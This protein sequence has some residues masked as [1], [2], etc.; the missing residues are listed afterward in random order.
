MGSIVRPKVALVVHGADGRHP[1]SAFV[2]VVLRARWAGRLGLADFTFVSPE[3]LAAG[4][5]LD[6]VDAVIVQRDA[7]LD[8]VLATA[9]AG[10]ISRR[11]IRLVHDVDDDFWSEES[12]AR[13]LGQDYSPARLAAFDVASTAADITLVSTAVLATR[14]P[15]STGAVVVVQNALDPELWFGGVPADP[16]GR[17]QGESAVMALDR[18]DV[19]GS[20][21]LYSGSHTHG[22]DL[23]LLRRVPSAQRRLEVVGVT[24]QS[25]SW[26]SLSHLASTPMP[27]PEYVRLLRASSARWSVGLAPLVSNGFNR[28][29]SDLKFLE[30][31]ALGI[32][33]IASQ[34][35]AYDEAGPHGAVLVGN[36]PDEWREAADALSDDPHG[37]RRHA[38]QARSHVEE[39]RVFRV[40]DGWWEA[41]GGLGGRPSS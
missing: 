17:P 13:L 38:R 7:L 33:T 28:G 4:Q 27:Y 41:V 21:Y 20:W 25:A 10:E 34:G 19:R 30:Y 36:D 35:T 29:K 22:D 2:R 11:G 6:G 23:E 40:D 12:R 9:A 18:D 32:P 5:H 26:Y 8:G 16:G 15:V 1:G 3:A 31:S 14:R 24:P 37:R 39:E